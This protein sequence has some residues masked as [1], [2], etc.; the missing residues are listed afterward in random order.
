MASSAQAVAGFARLEKLEARLEAGLADVREQFR[1]LDRGLAMAHT[2]QELKSMAS[3]ALAVSSLDM[4]RSDRARLLRELEAKGKVVMHRLD[5]IQSRQSEDSDAEDIES[6]WTDSRRSRDEGHGAGRPLVGG[7]ADVFAKLE[8]RIARLETSPMQSLH[9][10]GSGG[11]GELSELK[12]NLE[13]QLSALQTSLERRLDCMQAELRAISHSGSELRKRDHDK[14]C[15][16]LRH[17]LSRMQQQPADIGNG[18]PSELGTPISQLS[19]INSQ[20]F[21]MKVELTSRLSMLED[22]IA[23]AELVT[24]IPR[25]QAIE[26]IGRQKESHGKILDAQPRRK[27]HAY[28]SV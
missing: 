18:Q 3:T 14:F 2:Q 20:L 7:D 26:G 11:T 27:G 12:M 15:A 13:E 1:V 4:P 23:Q 21:M 22:T 19:V 16:E 8:S 28:A 25:L 5:D 24:I 9:G 17:E 6:S 10:G